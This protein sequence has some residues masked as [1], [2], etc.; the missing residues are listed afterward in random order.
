MHWKI[1][2]A[3]KG[4]KGTVSVPPDKSISH[5]AVMYGS[6]SEG[7]VRIRNFLYGKDCLSTFSAFRSL[8]VDIRREGKDVFIKGNGLRGLRS[9]GGDL[10]L[11]NSGTTMRIIAGILAG[12]EFDTVLTGDESL[13]SRPMNRIIEPLRNMGA[14]IRDIEGGA[15]AP[16]AIT[17][18][19]V[20]LKA[21][22][23]RLPV[24]SAQ[25]KS[26][27]LSAGLYAEGKTNVIEPFQSRDHTERMLSYLGADINIQGTDISITGGSVLSGGDISIPGDIS[28]AAFFMVAASVVKGSDI[29]IKNVGINPTRTGLISVL[30]RMGANIEITDISKGQEPSGNIRVKYAPL[31]GTYVTPEEVPLLIDE[32]PVLMIAN[33]CAE[34]RSVI[35]GVR[36]LRVKESDRIKTMKQNLSLLGSELEEVDDSIVITGRGESFRSSELESYGDHRIAMSMVVASLLS[37]KECIVKN[38]ACVDISYPGFIEDLSLLTS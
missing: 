11:G 9:P 35:E 38:T 5:R 25:V 31:K 8:G 29:V 1:E 26:C 17:G 15:H 3:K 18:R 28:S 7:R 12:Q 20:P 33:L 32:I 30:K 27:I 14:E 19:K 16:L 36:E 2:K 10:F 37:D 24:A 23:Y 34:G 13:S 6:L 22:K 4:L 21:I